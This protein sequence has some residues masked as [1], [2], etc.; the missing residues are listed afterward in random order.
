MFCPN[1]GANVPDH[2][3]FCAG[4]GHPISMADVPQNNASAPGGSGQ[5]PLPP[6]KKKTGL[7]VGLA[8]LVAV[9]L[10][11]V[12]AVLILR[13]GKEK[14][15]EQSVGS[16]QTAS[17]G[18]NTPA[19]GEKQGLPA[20][21]Q[22]AIPLLTSITPADGSS[23]GDNI[24]LTY[25]ADGFH[26]T[27]YTYADGS[28]YQTMEDDYD[29][30]G[31]V[32]HSR[33]E[34][35]GQGIT[36][37]RDYQY[38]E[39]GNLSHY[40]SRQTLEEVPESPVTEDI[41]YTCDPDGRVTQMSAPSGSNYTYELE[42]HSDGTVKA[43]KAGSTDTSA[44]GLTEYQYEDGYIASS[45]YTFTD[46][47]GTVSYERE[48]TYDKSSRSIADCG[49][50][51]TE[52]TRS[53][54]SESTTNYEY[55]EAFLTKDGILLAETEQTQKIL[56]QK[57]EYWQG[58]LSDEF[59]YDEEG[60]LTREMEYDDFGN[61][62]KYTDYQY[63]GEG[64]ECLAEHRAY[65]TDD[66]L[67]TYGDYQYDENGNVV[68][69][70]WYDTHAGERTPLYVYQYT[71]DADFSLLNRSEIAMNP[72][73]VSQYFEY[74]YDERGNKTASH[75]YALRK[76]NVTADAIKANGEYSYYTYDNEYDG[77]GRL[78]SS[79]LW[80]RIIDGEGKNPSTYT[81]KT[82]YEY[83]SDGDLVKESS[84]DNKDGCYAY[85]EYAYLYR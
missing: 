42:F 81:T 51:L 30:S 75:E 70:T 41:T 29:S 24:T 22:T 45:R 4:C 79:L 16:R 54:G 65:G 49:N 1:C 38:D 35:T 31:H 12:I 8:V 63:D 60:R 27:S 52:T 19:S 32:V 25:R 74:E 57:K 9:L 72:V 20:D 48:L 43:M 5:S 85:T 73:Y 66:L 10:A 36:I 28:L 40:A 18:Q 80:Y 68:S 53:G 83:D 6:P 76:A 55:T 69:K 11:A 64:R 58:D 77:Q 84:Y 33:Q 82:V 62:Y 46:S 47:D 59:T 56:Y 23:E 17:A 50:I 13:P 44:F 21:A 15:K 3:K 37:E 26:L 67:H 61:E 7:I 34:I 78:T 2:A 39:N 71:Y 14:A